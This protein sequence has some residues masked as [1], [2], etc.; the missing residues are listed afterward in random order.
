MI[1]EIRE[2]L[3]REGRDVILLSTGQPGLEPPAWLREEL[4]RELRAPGL[5]LY[6]YTPSRGYAALR[7]LIAEDQAALGGPEVDPGQVLVT[8]GG[9]AAMHAVM[10]ALVPEGG[11]VVL[12]DP[13][14]FGYEPLVNYVGARVRWVVVRPE[15]GYRPR[16]DDVAE[17]VERGRT[18]AIVIVTPDNPTGRGLDEATVRGIVEVAADADAWVISDEAYKTLVYEGGHP[19]PYRFDPER[20]VSINTFSKDPGLPGWRI[21]YVYGPKWA[22]DKIHLVHE[23]LVYCPPSI[24]QR[25]VEVYLSRRRERVEFIE[26]AKG[27]YRERRDALA[28]ALRELL[29][30]ASFHLPEG[31]MFIFADLTPY[32]AR[33][34]LDGEEFAKRLLLEEGV[35][36]VPGQY[37]GYAHRRAVRI[38]FAAE[39]PERL[40]A[41]VEAMARL[42][43]RMGA[44]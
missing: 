38:S 10:E 20:V 23:S 32:L 7:E 3:K 2:R 44:L 24:A 43:E 35:A 36:L 1:D 5:R 33:A 16:P 41:G 15:D 19:W 6:S 29:P 42:L 17:V 13:T 31:G 25:A 22:V 30:E 11:E 37:F 34:G 18:S 40:R 4:A 21:G 27:V 8:A 14:Y 9:Q 28:A 12:F 39:P 26:W